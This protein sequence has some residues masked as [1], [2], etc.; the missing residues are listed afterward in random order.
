[1]VPSRKSVSGR[2]AMVSPAAPGVGTTLIASRP[3]YCTRVAVTFRSVSLPG[4]TLSE[5][6]PW[7]EIVQMGRLTIDARIRSLDAMAGVSAGS[8]AV[9]VRVV[10]HDE[11]Q[12]RYTPAPVPAQRLMR[13]TPQLTASDPHPG[14]ESARA[15]AVELRPSRSGPENRT[16]NRG[17]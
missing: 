10:R 1:M 17:P 16:S 12:P 4:S 13:L 8:D 3:R 11:P 9:H 5:P 6:P 14:D 2:I 7:A 15:P